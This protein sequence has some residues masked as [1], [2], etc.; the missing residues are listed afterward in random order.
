MTSISESQI[1]IALI[2]ALIT[3]ILAF[4]LGKALYQ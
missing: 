3:S 1:S 2:A 4:R